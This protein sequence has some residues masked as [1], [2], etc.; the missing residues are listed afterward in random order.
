MSMTVAKLETKTLTFRRAVN[1]LVLLLS[2]LQDALGTEHLFVGVAI[3]LDLLGGVRL[4]VFDAS[5]FDRLLRLRLLV[6]LHREA[7]QNL[8]VDG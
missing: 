6:G 5:H 7:S 1:H 4:A 3:E 2:M 8:V